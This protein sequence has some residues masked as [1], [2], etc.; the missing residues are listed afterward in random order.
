MNK[1]IYQNLIMAALLI[2]INI[3]L[4]IANLGYIAAVCTLLVGFYLYFMK[5]PKKTISTGF[6]MGIVMAESGII[7]LILKAFILVD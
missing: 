5:T 3:L 6:W 7:C 1:K 2:I 4:F